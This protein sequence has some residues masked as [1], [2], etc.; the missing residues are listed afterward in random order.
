MSSSSGSSSGSGSGGGGGGGSGSDNKVFNIWYG[1][2]VVRRQ[3]VKI[4]SGDVMT[5]YPSRLK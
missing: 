1:E 5:L 2:A 3:I 4:I